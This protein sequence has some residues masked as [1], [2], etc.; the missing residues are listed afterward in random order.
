MIHESL[1]LFGLEF[2]IDE[3]EIWRLP[4]EMTAGRYFLQLSCSGI[5]FVLVKLPANEKFGV[6]AFEK[7]ADRISA[8]L[9]MPVAFGFE[10]ITRTQRDSLIERNVPFIVTADQ[11]YLPFLGIALSDR[12]TRQKTI[13]AEKMMPV[14]QALFLYMLYQGGRPIM[15]KDAAD[16]I[17]ATRTS[18]TRASEQLA[19][20]RLISQETKGKETWMTPLGGGLEYYEKAKPFL[21][22][23][24][25][26]IAAVRNSGEYDGFP[27]AG[28]SALAGFASARNPGIPVRAV[29]KSEIRE[30]GAPEIDLRWEPDADIV[31]LEL[32]KYDPAL[33]AKDGRVDPVSL[34]LSLE[35]MDEQTE[36]AAEAYLKGYPWQ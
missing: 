8:E 3:L 10:N 7:Q 13:R 1:K 22:S 32:W 30:D 36:E 23:P 34:A 5:R 29:L 4:P 15:K 33:F 17:G 2:R 27:L 14:T 31:R 35:H 24:V 19:A 6:I 25:Q 18:V 11:M 16:A 21:I 9:G 20:M 12:F 28:R 26:R